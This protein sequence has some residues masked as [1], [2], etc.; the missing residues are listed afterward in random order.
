MKA[1]Q[2]WFIEPHKV[3]V[4]EQELDALQADQVRVRNLCSGISAGTELLVYRGQLPGTMALDASL[5]AYAD[6]ADGYPLQYGYASVGVVEE[7]GIDVEASW[8]GQAV[9]SFQPHASHYQALPATLLPLPDG[10][11]PKAAVFLANMETAVNLLQDGHP[12]LG[13]R[14]VV[15]GQ[16]VV[17]ILVSRL[18]AEFPLTGLFALESVAF[19]REL[20]NKLGIDGVFDPGSEAALRKL[21]EQLSKEQ[22]TGGADLVFELSGSPDALNMA[23]DLCGFA[24]RIVVGSWYGTRQAEINFGERFHRNRIQI[25]SSQVSSIAP[26]LS[27]RWDKSRRYNVAWDMIKKCHPEQFI[28]HS[29]P[30]HS[31]S[32]AYQLLDESPQDA[33]QVVFDYQA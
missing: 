31:A 29:M 14:A 32:E 8:L 2:L 16:G 25:V 23:I 27:G 11:D 7:L 12:R 19:R 1:R 15:I 6:Q 17:G 5:E 3:E 24:G 4:R 18:L 30:F 33:F 9:F 26:D 10:V 28:T 22:A 21:N 20:S 13:E